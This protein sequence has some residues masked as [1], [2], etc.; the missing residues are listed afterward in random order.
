MKNKIFL[1]G[2]N[3]FIGRQVAYYLAENGYDVTAVVRQKKWQHKDIK[4]IK[5]DLFDI[6]QMGIKKDDFDEVIHMAAFV[7]MHEKHGRLFQ[8]NYKLTEKL[9]DFFKGS[10]TFF[11]YFSSIDAFGPTDDKEVNEN[12][13]PSPVT[14]YG[15][16]KLKTENLVKKSGLDYIILRIGNVEGYEGGLLYGLKKIYLDKSL[17]SKIQQFIFKNIITDYE[18]NVILVEDISRLVDKIF[19][20]KPTN[21]LYFITNNRIKMGQIFGFPK[22]KFNFLLPLLIFVCKIISFLKLSH[23]ICYITQGGLDRKYRNYSNKKVI[24]DLNMKFKNVL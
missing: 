7:G 21:Q 4:F 5:G 12:D 22:S 11:I 3:G 24:S 9:L 13:Y 10:G 16:A 14:D 1:T 8:G 23:V 2:A 17:Y 18:L 6:D 20:V 19:K 15:K